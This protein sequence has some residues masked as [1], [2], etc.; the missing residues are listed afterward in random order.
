MNNLYAKDETSNPTGTFKDR[1]AS[2]GVSKALEIKPKTIVVASDGNVAPAT[3][4]YAMIAGVKCFVFV[5]NY[6]S[7][8]RITQTMMYLPSTC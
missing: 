6:M 3:A 8:E 5:P 7:P 1:P 4:A 2:V